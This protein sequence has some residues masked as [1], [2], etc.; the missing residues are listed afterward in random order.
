MLN[1][2]QSRRARAL[3][4]AAACVFVAKVSAANAQAAAT[5]PGS[6]GVAPAAQQ[7]AA[8]GAAKSDPAASGA[9]VQEIV[10]TAQRRVERLQNVPISAEVVSGQAAAQQNLNSL[11]AMAEIVPSVHMEESGRS[12]DL[13]IRGIGS[14]ENAGFD[15][16]VGVFIDDIYHGRS[17]VTSATFLDLDNV[18]VLKGPQ[19][20][21]FGNNAIAG[22][23]NIVTNKPTDY[24]TESARTLYS[25]ESN[26]YA[27]EVAVGGPINDKL[28]FR[29]AGIVDGQTGWL[30]DVYTGGSAPDELNYA[31][32]L[33]LLYRPNSDFDVLLKMEASKNDNYSGL[34]LQVND[35]PPSAPF[36]GAGQFC[37]AAISKGVPN[38]G[39]SGLYAG[40]PGQQ[41]L[42]ETAET[43][44]TINYR[45]PNVTLTSVTGY[46][47][48]HYNLNLDADGTPETLLTSQIPEDFYQISQEFRVTSKDTGP[49][50]YMGGVY[51]QASRLYTDTNFNYAFLDDAVT[52]DSALEPLAS[53]LPIGQSETYLQHEQTYSAFGALTWNV[54][55][56]LS[57][58][59][60]L[61]ATAV[62][63]SYDL[64]LSYGTDTQTFGGF[65][66]LPQSLA[67]LPESLG[68]GVPAALNGE[69]TDTALLPSAKVQYK[70]APDVM[71]YVSYARGFKAG[72]FNSADTS[73]IAANVPFAPEYVNAY[74]VGLKSELLDRRLLLNLD[75]FRSDYDDLQ[76]AINGLSP[77]GT[78][79][80]LVRNAASS[81][82]QGVELESEWVVSEKFHIKGGLTYLDS[83]YLDYPDAGPTALQSLEGLQVQN[84]SGKPTEYAPP[85]AGNVGAVYSTNL[86][87]DYKL[88]AEVDAYWSAAYYVHASI[89]PLQMQNAFVRLNT[90][91]T[92][93]TPNRRWAFDLIGKNLANARILTFS[94]NLPTS[95]GSYLQSFEEGPSVSFQVRYHF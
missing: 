8:S 75:V 60:G 51:F 41:I 30:K 72:G 3:A 14:G 17:R 83:R 44:L 10:V 69:R 40:K 84:L 49:I 50:E 47:I 42:D 95:P 54:L 1:L 6:A 89:D 11:G 86:P 56:N 46:Y 62:H 67:S 34:A 45:L 37:Q 93:E 88:N 48:Y 21:F 76:V 92:I 7:P 22:A 81:R 63:K 2:V 77:S 55:H 18:E 94:T 33:S 74:E 68:I 25:P 65:V 91:I 4:T 64:D 78:I 57:V 35:C 80:S 5:E 70:F 59:G 26:A 79:I 90:Q 82:S 15:Q 53:Y 9:Q 71:A 85:W 73:G 24:F 27:T 29:V 36:P 31:G 87:G 61:R 66:P 12:N 13:Y 23:F 39:A 16:S 32:R 28:A 19:S 43:V 20:T 52:A 38:A 58:S